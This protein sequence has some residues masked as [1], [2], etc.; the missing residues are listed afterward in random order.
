M[1]EDSMIKQQNTYAVTI[2]DGRLVIEID[3]KYYS[4][5]TIDNA[6]KQLAGIFLNAG[7]DL[8]SKE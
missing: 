1:R 5:N 2:G 4:F 8:K 3:T 6:L 7:T